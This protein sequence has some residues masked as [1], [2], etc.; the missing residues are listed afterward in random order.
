MC[1][2]KEGLRPSR[3]VFV[4]THRNEQTLEVQSFLIR[5]S[6]KPPNGRRPISCYGS[7]VVDESPTIRGMVKIANLAKQWST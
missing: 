5:G 2:G 3:Y 7:L 6:G 1:M 4:I